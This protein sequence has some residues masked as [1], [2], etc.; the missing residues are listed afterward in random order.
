MLFK[1]LYIGLRELRQVLYIGLAIKMT[2]GLLKIGLTIAPP[3]PYSLIAFP[4]SSPYA[5]P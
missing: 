2:I 1:L 5:L 3:L 4:Y